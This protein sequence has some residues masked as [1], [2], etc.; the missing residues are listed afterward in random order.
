M[1]KYLIVLLLCI[2]SQNIVSAAQQLPRH[3]S[4]PGGI[5]LVSLDNIGRPKVYY[6][7]CPVMVIGE[8]KNWL[9]IVG[10][11]LSAKPG[12]HELIVNPD[13][14]GSIYNFE[15]KNKQYEKQYL[16]IKNKRQ[17]NPDADDMQR[18]NKEKELIAKAKTTWRDNEFISLNLSKPVEG[19]YSS[20]FGLRRFFN[21]QPR[22]PHSGLDIVAPEGTPV[23]AAADGIINNIGDYFFNGKTV[24]IDHGLGMI[25]MYC[26]LSNIAVKLNDYIKQGD[27]IGTVGQ[28][29][30]VTGAHLHWSITLN[31][32]SI[33]PLLFLSDDKF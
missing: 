31:N 12:G 27:I 15:V 25:T 11:P 29:G 23:K 22:K 9:A 28:T 3:E 14:E 10:I 8:N 19:S 4:V 30:R 20:P 13:S 1:N 6:G 32:T 18:I 5:A 26:H 7:K 33:N 17:V 21:N 24:F 16:K 2:C